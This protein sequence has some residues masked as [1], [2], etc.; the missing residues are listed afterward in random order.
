MLTIV[1]SSYHIDIIETGKKQLVKSWMPF[2]IHYFFLS[3]VEEEV[4]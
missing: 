3:C 4:V 2:L 1:V